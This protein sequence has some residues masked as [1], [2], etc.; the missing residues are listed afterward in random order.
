MPREANR[1]CG[2]EGLQVPGLRQLWHE[3]LWV[4]MHAL[5]P[6]TGAQVQVEA[7]LKDLVDELAV[8]GHM[9][10]GV[11]GLGNKLGPVLRVQELPGGLLLLDFEGTWGR[12]RKGEEHAI[13]HRYVNET[14]GKD[15]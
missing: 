3:A 14:D 7:A 15:G 13:H 11:K 9:S 1:Q 8:H 4:D 6:N 10:K 2:R 5:L 12:R